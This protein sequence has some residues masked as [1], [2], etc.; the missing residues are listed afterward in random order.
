MG[1]G[2]MHGMHGG[3]VWMMLCALFGIFLLVGIVLLIIWAI[4]T[5]WK[6]GRGQPEQTALDI[7]KKRYAN[8][9]ISSE[10]F[11]K[12]KRDIS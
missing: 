9:E 4:K 8:G 3:M 5:P 12:M 1:N 6:D 7:L 2:M 11:E 10:E